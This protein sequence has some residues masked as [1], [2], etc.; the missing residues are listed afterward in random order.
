MGREDFKIGNG[1]A[2]AVGLYLILCFCSSHGSEAGP[3]VKVVRI[4]GV[5]KVVKAQIGGDGTIHVLLDAEEGPRYVKST[6]GGVTFS[7][8]MTIVG[9]AAQKPGL[10]FQG[11]DLAI[12]K[13]G[14]VHVVMSCNAWKL[15]LP[16]EEWGVYY[17][18]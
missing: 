9:E 7:S 8:P 17:A 18:R 6:D 16:E 11:E 12:G 13:D 5:V 15:K 10:R 2:L 14:R 4:P 3:R 1:T